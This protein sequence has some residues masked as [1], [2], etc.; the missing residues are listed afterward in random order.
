MKKRL[1]FGICA[2]SMKKSSRVC[3]A[4]SLRPIWM[5]KSRR[6]T[7]RLRRLPG[8]GRMKWLGRSGG[9]FFPGTIFKTNIAASPRE[10]RRSDLKGRLS[11]KEE[12]AAY[13]VLRGRRAAAGGGRGAAAAARAG[14]GPT[15]E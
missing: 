6:S 14:G 2:F 4:A 15:A 13:W 12:T 7:D 3:R 9:I 11:I 10:K 8:F 5:G 1:V